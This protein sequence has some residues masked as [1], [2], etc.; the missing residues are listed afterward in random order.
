VSDDDALVQ[1]EEHCGGLDPDLLKS[2]RIILVAGSFPESVTAAVVWLCEQGLDIVLVQI[3]A[4]QCEHELIITVDQIWPL[5]QVED[6]T[7]APVVPITKTT[8]ATTKKRPGVTAVATL[9][10]AG[11]IADGTELRIVPAGSHAR[12]VSTWVTEEPERGRAI[13]R[14][15][16][17]IKALEWAA[18]GQ[19]YSASGLAEEVIRQAT[20]KEASVNGAEWWALNDGTSLAELAGTSP[21]KRDWSRL[22]T[23]L[24]KLD[25]GSWTTY[26]D[27]AEA[28]GSHPIAVGQHLVRCNVCEHA[29]R[30]LGSDGRPR[31]N[32]AWSDPADTR[33]PREVLEREGVEFISGAAD[34]ARRLGAAQ[35][36]ALP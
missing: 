18:D 27:V 17:K 14:T 31:P 15:G 26:G 4:W 3:G 1:L 32:F 25:A 12:E 2:P 23:I 36:A 6:F 33:T 13:W 29:W 8:A 22:H 20:G 19:R 11:V 24:A 7:V 5:P 21:A 35:L 9:T 28:I 16:Q 34:P 10:D 30:V